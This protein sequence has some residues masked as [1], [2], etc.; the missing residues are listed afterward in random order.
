MNFPSKIEL[1]RFLIKEF[2]EI[3]LERDFG[4]LQIRELDKISENFL[5]AL[6]AKQIEDDEPPF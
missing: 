6:L 1:T 4:S 3:G 5:A 2:R